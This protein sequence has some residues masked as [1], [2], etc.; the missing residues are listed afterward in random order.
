MVR[1]S[2]RMPIEMQLPPVFRGPRVDDSSRAQTTPYHIS[3]I[4]LVDWWKVTKGGMGITVGV[5]D[6]GIDSSHQEFQNKEI[7]GES[8]IGRRS[9]DFNDSNGHGTHVASTICGRSVGVAPNADLVVAKVLGSNGLGRS[10]GVA[11][12]IDYLR[13]SGCRIVNLSLGGP[14]DDEKTRD[15]VLR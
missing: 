6:T 10:E 8:F 13:E 3:D 4:G 7:R 9:G 14:Y 1:S 11:E 12:G 2:G 5:A 15:S